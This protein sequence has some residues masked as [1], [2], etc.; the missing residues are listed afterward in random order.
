MAINFHSADWQEIAR[1]AA[2]EQD[3]T[4]RKNDA[5][6]L[7]VEQTAAFRGEL[8]FIKRLLGLPA[9]AARAQQVGSVSDAPFGDFGT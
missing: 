6:E 7:S 4:R 3:A 1:W 2:Q 8:R 9:Q 5:L